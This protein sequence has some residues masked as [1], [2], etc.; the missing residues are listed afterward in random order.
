MFANLF[1]TAALIVLS[2]VIVLW[3]IGACSETLVEL[4]ILAGNMSRRSWPMVKSNVGKLSIDLIA[5]F[6]AIVVLVLGFKYIPHF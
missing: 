2:F 6:V 5:I 1:G 4:E 3:G